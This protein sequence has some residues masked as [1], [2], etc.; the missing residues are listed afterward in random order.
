MSRLPPPL[1][2][3]PTDAEYAMELIS[4]RV[5]KGLPIK[6][7]PRKRKSPFRSRDDLAESSSLAD[8]SRSTGEQD[9]AENSVDWEKWGE[10]VDKTKAWAGQVKGVL[11]DGNWKSLDNWTSINP[12]KPMHT[13]SSSGQHVETYSKYLYVP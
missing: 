11:R 2:H 12:L 8:Q 5:A 7:K 13:L 6:P 1:R 4:Q 10:R 3:S 9:S